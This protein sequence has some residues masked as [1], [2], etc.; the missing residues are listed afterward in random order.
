MIVDE[1]QKI[2]SVDSQVRAEMNRLTFDHTILLTG[3]PIQNNMSELWSLLNF[4]DKVT[5]S[6]QSEFLQRHGDI[7]T[8]EQVHTL[9]K[10]IGHY[11]LRRLKT[12][13]QIKLLAK[14]EVIVEV[15]LTRVQKKYY[16]A[17]YE[18]NLGVLQGNKKGSAAI[19][20]RNVSMQLRKCCNH[21]Y[22]LSS[23]EDEVLEQL[24]EDRI[25]SMSGSSSHLPREL[26]PV[27]VFNQLVASSGK[28]V[29]LDKLLPKLR[30][31]D[32]KVLI[33]SQM[34]RVLD[35]L[36]DYC[37]HCNYQVERLDGG[38]RGSDRQISIDRFNRKENNQSAFIFLLSTRAGGV[39]L[40]LTAADTVILYDSDWNP[41]NDIQAQDRVHRIGQT[42]PVKIYRLVTR[43]TYEME[44]LHRASMKLGLDKAVLGSVEAK[45]TTTT[46]ASIASWEK[47]SGTDASSSLSDT[48]LS[49]FLAAPDAGKKRKG[50]DD[51]AEPEGHLSR[52]EM[53]R[54][55]KQGAYNVFADDAEGDQRA[56]EF[57]AA[58][59]DRILE[60]SQ[61]IL[62][63]NAPSTS[64]A[65]SSFSKATFLP[66]GATEA[67][68]LNDPQFWQ[69]LGMKDQSVDSAA[70]LIIPDDVQRGAR[71]RAQQKTNVYNVDSSY[72][73]IGFEDDDEIDVSKMGVSRGRGRQRLADAKSARVSKDD[74]EFEQDTSSESE[75][76]P[77]D[78]NAMY[79]AYFLNDR[80][81]KKTRVGSR[82]VYTPSSFTPSTPL[83]LDLDAI[84]N[85]L[86]H[87]VHPRTLRGRVVFRVAF[88]A[89][90]GAGPSVSL[91]LHIVLLFCSH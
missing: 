58:D 14:E 9:S 17:I 70:A 65:P 40:S 67:L 60:R 6:S 3:T 31:G 87:L 73:D 71:V 80:T 33:F 26:T 7:C 2:K 88:S 13:L 85:L 59:I 24:Q 86:G 1:A 74:E 68:D 35:M 91:A 76:E 12:D 52:E 79:D 55:L 46:S 27:D 54:M 62:H 23:V 36:E 56:S 82:Q 25:A 44:M 69:K 21:P 53:E 38:I 34:K 47:S 22:L 10:E 41:Q 48:A 30:Q 81:A 8:A 20:L 28:M 84:L 19:S 39:G 90:P 32:H 45:A 29:L 37:V 77:L 57:C 78:D 50:P 89:C 49:T 66:D 15:E 63:Q 16:K 43:G 83:E 51:S 4:M 5:F 64:A 72:P 75:D 18:H 61:V 42:K 11:I